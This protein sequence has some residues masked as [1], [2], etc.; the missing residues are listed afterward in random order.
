QF[1]DGVRVLRR[2]SYSKS[3]EAT[4]S[5]RCVVDGEAGVL[6]PVNHFR[7][8]AN[9]KHHQ[10]LDDLATGGFVSRLFV[11]R[12][13]S[14]GNT[15][16]GKG[17]ARVRVRS[18]SVHALW[19]GSRAC[20]CSGNFLRRYRVAAGLTQ[21]AGRQTRLGQCARP[22]GSGT[23]AT[24]LATLRHWCTTTIVATASRRVNP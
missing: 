23:W 20:T 14:V 9:R 24:E 21:K 16:H 17:A 7:I 13:K 22:V 12:R 2:R 3:C 15:L 1:L 18:L 11:G 10:E 19:Q 6:T 5:R 4:R 8:H